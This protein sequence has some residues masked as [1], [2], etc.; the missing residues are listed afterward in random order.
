[1]KVETAI[2][3]MMFCAAALTAAAQGGEAGCRSR[4][5]ERALE[6]VWE[7]RIVPDSAVGVG[8]SDVVSF[9]L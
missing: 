1:M 4:E 9:L 3:A 6:K 5:A 8:K 7:P 2:A